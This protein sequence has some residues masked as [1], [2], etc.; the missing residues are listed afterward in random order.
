MA[1]TH[2]ITITVT[3]TGEVTHPQPE[4]DESPHDE[5]TTDG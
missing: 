1:D 5:E 4:T 3:A 2:T